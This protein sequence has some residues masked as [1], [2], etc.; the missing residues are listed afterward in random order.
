MSELTRCNHCTLRDIEAHAKQTGRLVTLLPN[1]GPPSMKGTTVLVHGADEAP[2]EKLHWAAWLWV[3][4]E[5][6]AC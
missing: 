1:T 6:C 4:T 5:A 3:I 2:D